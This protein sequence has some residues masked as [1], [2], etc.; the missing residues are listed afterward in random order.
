[1]RH[2]PTPSLVQIMACR[3]FGAKPFS[4]PMMY[5]CQLDKLQSNC[6]KNYNIFIKKNVWKRC[7]ENCSHFV[8]A[9]MCAYHN[10]QRQFSVAYRKQIQM[11]V[12]TQFWIILQ[13]VSDKISAWTYY[14]CRENVVTFASSILLIECSI[15][16]YFLSTNFIKKSVIKTWLF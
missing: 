13:F 15:L 12:H 1:M 14:L 5:Y 8:S 9:S 2:Q 3:L 11:V 6:I 10:R 4:E 16:H 7:L